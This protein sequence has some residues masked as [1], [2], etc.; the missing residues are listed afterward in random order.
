MKSDSKVLIC[1]N[2]PLSIFPFYD[3][4]THGIRSQNRLSAIDLSEYGISREINNIKRILS[5]YFLE[6]KTFIF[7]PC[8]DQ[9]INKINAY[10]PDIIFNFV[11]SIEGISNYEYCVAGLFEL[12]GYQFTG[13]PPICLGNCLDK[14]KTKKIL[15]SHKIKTPDYFV[16][17]CLEKFS[18][19]NFTLAFPVIVKLLTEDASIGISEFSVVKNR[20]EL[21]ARIDF[22]FSNYHR[23][24]IIEEYIDGRELNVAIL[25]GKILPVSEIL[26]NGL[27]ENLPKIVTYEGKWISES[28]YYENTKPNCPA[29][30]DKTV[31]RLLEETAMAAFNAMGCRD[32]ARVDVRLN[33]ENVPYVIEVNPNP[34][35]SIDSGF[36]RAAAAAGLPYAQLI[37]GIA[38]LAL[39]R[40]KYD[41][42]IKAS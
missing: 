36:A 4:K 18:V 41:S 9:T 14:G 13:N 8:I 16:A 38:D 39:S 27:P 10:S 23:D 19:K 2:A 17:S 21:Q 35:I 40:K 37:T 33:P 42:Q 34:D 31:K 11:E 6:V 32:Y 22:L 30:L 25:G 7:N 28:I 12:L 5:D 29:E 3:G 15:Q 26:F 20:N 24:V 1:Y